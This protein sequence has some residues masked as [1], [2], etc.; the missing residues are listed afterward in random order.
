MLIF[1]RGKN[2]QIYPA[3]IFAV[4]AELVYACASEAHLARVESSSLSHGTWWQI[5]TIVA[6][7][8]QEPVSAR[9]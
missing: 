5:F 6:R 8:L 2:W 4:V 1:V 3:V 9:E 7:R